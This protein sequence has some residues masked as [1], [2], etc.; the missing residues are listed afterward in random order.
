M[1]DACLYLLEQSEDKL[2]GLFNPDTPP[3]VNVGCG[4]DLTIRELAE[5]VKELVGFRGTLAFD[6]SKPDGTKR[7]VMDVS[8]MQ[9]LGW[10]RQVALQ[11][12]VALAYKDFLE[13]NK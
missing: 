4:E 7:K 9:K 3:L 5:L 6:S 13:K 11:T 2:E 8:K 12:G 1:A 10:T